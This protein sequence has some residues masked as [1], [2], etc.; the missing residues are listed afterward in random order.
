MSAQHTPW[1]WDEPSERREDERAARGE[2]S[3]DERLAAD[4]QDYWDAMRKG[5]EPDPRLTWFD[6]ME[7]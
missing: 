2:V 7:D 5:E 3:E 6:D 4:W 1:H